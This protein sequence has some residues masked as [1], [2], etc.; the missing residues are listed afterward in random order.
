MLALA[1]AIVVTGE[2]VSMVSEAV[3]TA[4]PVLL[5]ELPGPVAADRPVHAAASSTTGACA[6][7][8]DASSTG[9]SSRW[10]TRGVVAAEMCRRFGY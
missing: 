1:D 2:S 6:R 5:A 3:A 10:T 8:W 9:R 7:L 4:A